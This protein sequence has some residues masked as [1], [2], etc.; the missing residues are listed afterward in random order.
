MLDFDKDNE[1]TLANL[2]A[3]HEHHECDYCS[4]GIIPIA[5]TVQEY[6]CDWE[7]FNLAIAESN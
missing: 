6:Y 1:I 3:N 5:N 7:C 2:I 4:K